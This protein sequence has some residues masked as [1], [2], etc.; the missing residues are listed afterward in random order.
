MVLCHFML[1]ENVILGMNCMYN[2]DGDVEIYGCT[3]LSMRDIQGMDQHLAG[4]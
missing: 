4:I 2:V 1:L 3:T